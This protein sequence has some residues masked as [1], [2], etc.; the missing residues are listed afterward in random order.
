MVESA[1]ARVAPIFI[2][3]TPKEIEKL[4][5]SINGVVFPGGHVMLNV[6]RYATVGKQIFELA[7]KSN[8]EGR[9]FPIWAECLGLE[10]IS[11]I[12]SGYGFAKGQYDERL[13]TSNDARNF[14][15]TLNFHNLETSTFFKNTP[16]RFIHYMENTPFA[17]N[18]HDK[19][20][21]PQT[22]RKIKG[23]Y[24]L[25]RIT[26]TSYDREGVEFISTLEGRRYPFF[27]LH[28]HPSKAQFEWSRV[29][30]IFHSAK[31][32]AIS[33]SLINGFVNLASLN[34][35]KFASIQEE[36]DALIY[37]YTTTY[38]EPLGT[39]MQMYFFKYDPNAV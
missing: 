1:G 8:R 3:R 19:G 26:T 2:D 22:Y 37:K 27:L 31:A 29:L 11:L 7:L 4:F 39:S 20:I 32:V 18:N 9:V 25:F 36:D 13:L 6:S 33:Q 38:T 12:A 21:S 15:T 24:S 35:H 30:N 34:D 10:I 17:Y 16:R 14:S 23:L 5:Y 28:W